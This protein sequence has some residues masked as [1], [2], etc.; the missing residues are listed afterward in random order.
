MAVLGTGLYVGYK[1]APMAPASSLA[2][3][4]E[5]GRGDTPLDDVDTVNPF[6]GNRPLHMAL[7][8]IDKTATTDMTAEDNPSR[9]DVVMLLTM[10]PRQRKAQLLSLPRDTY[11]R[12]PGYKGKTKLGHAYAYGGHELAIETIEDFMD[13]DIDHYA[14]VDYQAVEKLVNAVGGVEVD[15]PFDYEYLDTYVV[16]NLRIN[17]KKG[18]QKL[19]GA[20]AVR[21]LRI[22]KQYE[23]QDIGR[24]QA[25]QGFLMTLFDQI[26]SP[27]LLFRFNT[28]LDI[29][30][31]NVET[32][33]NY[34]EIAY[35]AKFGLSLD[36]EDI[37]TDTLVGDDTYIGDIAYYIVDEDS[38]RE[39]LNRFSEGK[40]SYYQEVV[41]DEKDQAEE[42]EED[43]ED[44]EE[45]TEDEG[46][47][48]KKEGKLGRSGK[49]SSQEENTRARRN[50]VD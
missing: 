6:K 31:N 18:P 35:L 47:L 33:L 15:I 17:F 41:V 4:S 40:G 27:K 20:D 39:Q 34:G 7:F 24:I 2:S 21:Y 46:E 30:N 44:V 9:S 12:V 36:R 28:L 23:D 22:R 16:P 1:I 26:K 38:A 8:G 25:Q 43:Q 5:E 45:T 11:V 14:V 48:L 3:S 37:I 29:A 42:G 10:D 32:D 49:G 19:N 13:V 50:P